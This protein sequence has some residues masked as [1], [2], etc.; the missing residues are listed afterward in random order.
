M[1][2]HRFSTGCGNQCGDHARFGRVRRASRG[3]A[4]LLPLLL[5]LFV[6]GTVAV[7]PLLRG[8]APAP[9]TATS[10][11]RPASVT[12]ARHRGDERDTR[13]LQSARAALAPA[14]AV[15]PA[16]GDSPAD[17]PPGAAV[18]PRPLAGAVGTAAGTIRAGT[19][20]AGLPA[21]RGPPGAQVTAPLP[22][23]LVHVHP[24]PA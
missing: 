3:V 18:L 22:E 4:S 9:G 17:V 8:P 20:V 16:A 23:P 13:A 12:P 6:L 1:I 15:H 7:A 24:R 10:S 14:A 5:S 2:T 21:P 11:P 19:L